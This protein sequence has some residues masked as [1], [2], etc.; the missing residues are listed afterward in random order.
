MSLPP[1]S[2]FGPV[3]QFSLPDP[4]RSDRPTNYAPLS[5]ED[6]RILDSFRVVL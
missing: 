1:I 2:S 4:G 3:Q 5:S 6:R